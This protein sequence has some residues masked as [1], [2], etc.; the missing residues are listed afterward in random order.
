MTDRAGLGASHA[1]APRVYLGT[2]ALGNLVWE[3]AHL[4]LYTNRKTRSIREKAFA[5][6][7]CTGGDFLIA[8]SSLAIAIVIGGERTWPG[9]LLVSRRPLHLARTH[10]H[11]VQ[12][13]A[14]HRQSG[15]LG[16]LQ[17]HG[18]NLAVSAGGRAVTAC[19]MDRRTVHFG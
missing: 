16:G 10:L 14:Q 5:L 17:S 9:Q 13:M 19:A 11:G 1:R 8:L 4:P 7:Y 12:R 3:A 15:G 18:R 6:I 2:I